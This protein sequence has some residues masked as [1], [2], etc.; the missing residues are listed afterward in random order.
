MAYNPSDDEGGVNTYARPG[1]N[2]TGA[3]RCWYQLCFALPHASL[4]AFA[5]RSIDFYFFFQPPW[6]CNRTATSHGSEISR[7][8]SCHVIGS[9]CAVYRMAGRSRPRN[10][11]GY[12]APR[13]Q[14]HRADAGLLDQLASNATSKT[15]CMFVFRE[16]E[17]SCDAR[18]TTQR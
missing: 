4:P 2:R 16:R 15:L 12:K 14:I 7:V 11:I 9:R 13:R 3:A 6:S 17:M 10:P 18:S 5:L 8:S 1:T